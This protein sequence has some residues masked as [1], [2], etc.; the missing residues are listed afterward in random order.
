MEVI[1]RAWIARNAGTRLQFH[2]NMGDGH[3]VCSDVVDKRDRRAIGLF[4]ITTSYKRIKRNGTK[5]GTRE[6]LW[7]VQGHA[8]AIVTLD[9]ALEILAIIRTAKEMELLHG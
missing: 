8:G 2:L 4:Y 1:D 6:R 5:A 9:D 7:Y 3:K